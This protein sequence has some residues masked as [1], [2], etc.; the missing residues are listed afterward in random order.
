VNLIKQSFLFFKPWGSFFSF[1]FFKKQFVISKN[2][3]N[4]PNFLAILFEF[5][6][7]GSQKHDWLEDPTKGTNTHPR[8]TS[9]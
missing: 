2:S 6:T 8:G 1:S 5:K 9:L 4:F 7:K 3:Q